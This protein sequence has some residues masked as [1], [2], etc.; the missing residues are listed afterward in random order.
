MKRVILL[1]LLVCIVSVVFFRNS[2]KRDIDT[3]P[4]SIIPTVTTTPLKEAQT[5]RFDSYEY[6]YE[7]FIVSNH[8]RITLIPNFENPLTAEAIIRD[9]ACTDAINTGFY[10]TTNKPIGLWKNEN[11]S[12]GVAQSNALLNGYYWILDNIASIAYTP[13]SESK[14]AFQTG[15]VLI[16]K[17]DPVKLAIKNDEP[18]R[19]MIAG[20]LQNDS[21]IFMTIYDPLSPLRGPYLNNLPT[22]MEMISRQINMK[23]ISAINLDGGTA[24]A[25]YSNNKGVWEINPAGSI[26]CII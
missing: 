25:F 18:A 8:K 1:I 6:A 14:I 19:R 5:I 20:I 21:S 12:L 11:V 26:L 2:Q 16:F 3:T 10:S 17:N 15:P 24:S 7:Y 4:V 23:L 13:P 22:I 9:N